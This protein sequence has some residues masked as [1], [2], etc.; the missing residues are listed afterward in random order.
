MPP[1][2]RGARE[3]RSHSLVLLS[4]LISTALALLAVYIL[5]TKTEDFHVMGWYANYVIPIGAI[6]VGVVA[7][8]GY[9]LASWLSGVKITRSLL[10][11][12]LVLNLWHQ[13][14]IEA[15]RPTRVVPR[16]DEVGARA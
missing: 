15:I 1:A 10:W 6:L 5:D 7:S 2:P 4:G 8:S 13:R 14:W 12:V 3:E 11:T 16:V 9:G